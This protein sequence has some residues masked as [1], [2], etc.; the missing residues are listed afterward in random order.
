MHLTNVRIWDGIADNYIQADTIEIADGRIAGLGGNGADALDCGGMT[1]IPGLMDAHVHL[2]LDPDL[3]SPDDQK[4][5]PEAVLPDM[6]KRAE[7]MV[8]ARFQATRLT[9]ARIEPSQVKLNWHPVRRCE[10]W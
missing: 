1:V 8:R 2:C 4:T 3:R 5:D 7:A 9:G 10:P 6:R